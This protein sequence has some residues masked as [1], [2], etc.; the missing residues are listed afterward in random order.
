MTWWCAAQGGPWEWTWRA[1]PGVWLVVA[2][3]VATYVTAR[4]RTHRRAG[5]QAP[6]PHPDSRFPIPDSR[7]SD[8]PAR[9]W[10]FLTGVLVFWIAA[11][12]PVGALAAG[13]LVSVHAV[14]FLLFAMVAAP[15]LLHG[16]PPAGL[17][18][19]LT[20][21][22]VRPAARRL[23]RPLPA[24]VTFNV[25][26]L[27]TH[28]PQVVDALRTSQLGSFAMD[29]AWLGAGI[30]F[31]WQVLGPLPEFQPL[32][33]PGRLLFLVAN[34]FLPTVPASFLTFADYPLYAVYELAPRA[35]ALSATED[36]QLAGLVM[37]LGGG[38]IIFAAASAL[39][40]RWFRREAADEAAQRVTVRG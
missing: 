28:L 29:M 30:V 12:W 27:G 14:Q 20:R 7:S 1:Y 18:S 35:G 21:P 24:F 32:S 15:L 13:Y 5:A 4:W 33:Y 16:M 10:S 25:V 39:F 3:M 9:T 34:L 2:A 6:P 36:Q 26:M 23:T 22:I 40:F 38:F 19:L 11:D 37:K 17:R 31:W 8:A